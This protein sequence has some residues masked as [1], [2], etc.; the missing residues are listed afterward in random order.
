MKEAKYYKKLENKKV[1]CELCPRECTILPNNTGAC[2]VRKN[3]DGKLYSLV[4]GKVC[5]ISIDPIEK[6]PL[7]HFFPGEETLSLATVGCNLFCSFCQNYEISQ[8]EIFGEYYEPKQIIELAEKYR[9]RIIS[10]TYTE[11][12]IFYEYALDIMKLAKKK[13][14]KNVWVTNGY[15]N[16]KPIKEMAPYLDAVNVD[17]KGNEEVY[18]KLCKASLE[19][20]LN[21]L[22]EYKK[23]KIW[24]EITSLIIPGYNDS[25]EWITFLTNWIKDNLG[26]DIPLHLSRFFP[27]YKM[28]DVKPTPISSLE[29]LYKIAKKNLNYVYI[30][31]VF[32]S[33]YESTYCPKCNNIIIERSAY[34]IKFKAHVCEKCKNKIEGVF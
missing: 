32:D 9:V 7:F 17:V 34:N 21:T 27:H 8:G 33:K 31:N 22:L 4:Y 23:N 18:K 30:G 20:V 15:T 26:K 25:K 1:K 2:R 24:I 11:P 6:K 14:F 3:L 16:P 19:P 5:S 28:L 29:E 13:N 10:Y 12:T